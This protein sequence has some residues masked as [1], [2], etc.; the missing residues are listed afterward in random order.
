MD[1]SGIADRINSIQ[2]VSWGDVDAKEYH[3]CNDVGGEP[4]FILSDE[5][6]DCER[7]A[8]AH[9]PGWLQCP[10][11]VWEHG[12]RKFCYVMFKPEHIEELNLILNTIVKIT[13]DEY[14]DDTPD[15]YMNLLKKLDSA[16]GSVIYAWKGMYFILQFNVLKQ[17]KALAYFTIS[18]HEPMH[19]PLTFLN[20]EGFTVRKTDRKEVLLVTS[21]ESVGHL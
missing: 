7:H 19:I 11:E 5:L 21:N 20:I 2:E 1:I 16:M 13:L 12:E 8:C 3:Y 15:P 6:E 18:C 4:F 14:F 10:S 17:D 9:Y